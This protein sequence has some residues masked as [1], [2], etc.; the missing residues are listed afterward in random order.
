[1]TD[2]YAGKDIFADR[3]PLQEEIN[4]IFVRPKQ[5]NRQETSSKQ[6]VLPCHRR[7]SLLA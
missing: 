2:P 5:S 4:D 7:V 3:F 1:M 6:G